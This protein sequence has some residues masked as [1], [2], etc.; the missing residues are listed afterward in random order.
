M[1][2]PDYHEYHLLERSTESRTTP[3]KYENGVLCATFPEMG[4]QLNSM[5]DRRQL[6]TRYAI[7]VDVSVNVDNKLVVEQLFCLQTVLSHPFLIAITNDQTEPLLTSIFWQ[8]LVDNDTQDSCLQVVAWSVVK[9]VIRNFIKAQ[10][11]Q[12]RSLDDEEIL[13]IQCMLFLP[14]AVRALNLEELEEQWYGRVQINLSLEGVVRLQYRLLTEFI[15]D[16]VLVSKK[17]FMQDKCFSVIDMQTELRHSVWQWMYRATE[18]VMD[19]GHKICPSPAAIEKKGSKTKKQMA[20]AEDYQTMLSLFNNRHITMLS[21][22]AVETVFKNR[23]KSND[24]LQK[25]MLLRFCEDNAGYL[26]FAFSNADNDDE[27]RAKPL[28]GSISC[29]QIKDFKQGLPEVLMD[30]PFPKN[31]DRLG[32]FEQL[33]CAVDVVPTFSCPKKRTV[34][35]NYRTLRLQNDGI[36]SQDRWKTRVNPLTGER[37]SQG[38]KA[39]TPPL[40]ISGAL[41]SLPPL[42]GQTNPL[43]TASTSSTKHEFSDEEPNEELPS[44][45]STASPESENETCP[46]NFLAAMMLLVQQ[47]AQFGNLN[48]T[49]DF[50]TQYNL[51]SN[52]GE[53]VKSETS[54]KVPMSISKRKGKS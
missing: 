10:Y 32:K 24:E 16:D 50:L 46:N 41:D 52:E 33:I 2:A 38:E 1:S 4:V 42:S 3:L 22:D 47:G 34:F 11:S 19:V 27:D 28:F 29:E 15:H 21:M 40:S 25:I 9:D 12:A 53:D 14:I 36:V 35:H 30:E 6:S 39:L 54:A 5:V 17:Q 43:L 44:S 8:R 23:G 37:L 51:L 45:I 7:Q 49:P 13:H 18:M 26:S 31:F 48:L 20:A